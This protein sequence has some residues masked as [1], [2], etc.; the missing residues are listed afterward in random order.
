MDQFD[1]K[2]LHELRADGRITHTELGKRVGLSPSATMRRVQEL[3]RTGV[4]A[5]YRAVINPQKIGNAFTAMIGVGLND[6]SKAAQQSFERSIS[7]SS[8][9]VECHNVTGTIEY[10][11]RVEVPDLAAYK[12]FHTEILGSLPQVSTLTTYAILSSPKDMRA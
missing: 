3:E 1:D 6:H 7:A 9:V 5:G 12:H 4:I 2:I 8:A 11:L 10:I